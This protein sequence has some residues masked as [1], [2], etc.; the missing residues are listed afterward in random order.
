MP[1]LNVLTNFYTPLIRCF[2]NLMYY[3]EY[4]MLQMV[5]WKNSNGSIICHLL[6]DTLRKQMSTYTY[7]G[8]AWVQWWVNIHWSGMG[9]VSTTDSLIFHFVASVANQ[10]AVSSP[11]KTSLLGFP[12]PLLNC[13]AQIPMWESMQIHL[14]YRQVVNMWRTRKATWRRKISILQ[15]LFL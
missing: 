13:R 15:H 8:V 12:K 6:V 3:L 7:T 9:S 5:V 10:W 2:C 1:L 14:V 4:S 11:S